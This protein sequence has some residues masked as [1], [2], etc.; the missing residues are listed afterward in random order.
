MSTI[1]V[2]SEPDVSVAALA[3]ACAT[4]AHA[5]GMDD[6]LISIHGGEVAHVS[7]NE[8]TWLYMSGDW[9][10]LVEVKNDGNG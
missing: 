1:S 4:V 7:T 6:M 9:Y 3:E 8:R 10:E 2:K 5:I